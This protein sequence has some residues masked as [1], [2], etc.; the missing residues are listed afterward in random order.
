MSE[1]QDQS[2]LVPSL[3]PQT[4]NPDWFLQ[5]LV[6]IVNG[7]EI[8]FPITLNVGGVLISGELVSGHKYFE[9]FAKE[10]KEGMFNVTPG[11]TSKIEEYFKQ[12]GDIY[13]DKKEEA[14]E[15]TKPLPSYIHLGNAHIF[16]S[17]GTPIPANRGV[18][19]RGRLEAVDGFILGTLSLA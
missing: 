10:L 2:T 3:A 17:G 11:V 19:W 16:N 12:F 5:M 18:W 7:S 1:N 15:N 13:V 14:D 9:G 6:N 4:N 8:A